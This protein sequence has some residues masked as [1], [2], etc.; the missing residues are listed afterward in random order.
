[1]SYSCLF[2]V[3]GSIIKTTHSAITGSSSP[4]LMALVSSGTRLSLIILHA[5]KYLTPT[6]KDFE[7]HQNAG[8]LFTKPVYNLPIRQFASKSLRATDDRFLCVRTV[9]S[10]CPSGMLALLMTLNPALDALPSSWI[11]LKVFDTFCK[12]TEFYDGETT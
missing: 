7:Q 9:I 6:F 1:M 8:M 3:C 11:L 12:P 4:F 5:D 10:R 2:D